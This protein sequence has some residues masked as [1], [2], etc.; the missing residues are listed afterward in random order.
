MLTFS[1]QQADFDAVYVPGGAKGAERLSKDTD[2]QHLLWQFHESGKLVAC[3]CAGSLAAKA[4]GVNLGGRIT[5]HPS[6]RSPFSLTLSCLWLF[7][8]IIRTDIV[9]LFVG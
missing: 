9:T 6:V 2:V 5:S 3:I 8:P 4:A 1:L 7:L